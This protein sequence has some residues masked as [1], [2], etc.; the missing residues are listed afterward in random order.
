MKYFL[1]T[2]MIIYFI[3]GKYPA[4]LEHLRT[5][6]AQSIVIPAVVLAEIE[7]GAQK[8]MDYQMTI[9]KYRKFTRAFE[10]IPFSGASIQVY[11][12]IRRALEK[13]GMP[14]GPNDLMIAATV[15][16][17]DGILVTHNTKEF[18]RV[19]GLRLEDWIE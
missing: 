1:D 19:P 7:Y 13:A 10:T 16:A 18:S 12:E 8:S 17:N 4:L 15:L 11:G 6:P 14:I 5:I 9:S 3:K 2:N